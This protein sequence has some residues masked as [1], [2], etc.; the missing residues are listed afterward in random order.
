MARPALRLTGRKPSPHP[1]PLCCGHLC[2]RSLDPSLDPG[3]LYT[4]VSVGLLS[5]PTG[6]SYWARM[7]VKG[8]S[9][10]SLGGPWSETEFSDTKNL[11][12]LNLGSLEMNLAQSKS[13]G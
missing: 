7:D 10:R 9:G 4:G 5:A 13:L 2:R 3:G 1:A 12:L 6:W 8:Q 11:L